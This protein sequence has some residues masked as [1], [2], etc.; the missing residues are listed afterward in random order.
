MLIMLMLQEVF[1][2]AAQDG[3]LQGSD[4]CGGAANEAPLL[5][6]EDFL[7]I[8]NDY[9]VIPIFVQ[10]HKFA[11]HKQVRGCRPCTRTVAGRCRLQACT[12]QCG[13]YLFP[14]VLHSEVTSHS[15]FCY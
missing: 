14:D 11:E 7:A 2:P 3:A 13:S 5:A 12:Q 9:D 6:Y 8:A 15:H 1:A 4:S 10:P